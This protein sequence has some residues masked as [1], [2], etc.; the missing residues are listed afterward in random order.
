MQKKKNVIVIGAGVSGM[1]AGIYLLKN[2]FNVTLLERNSSVGGLC[3]GWYRKGRYIDGCIHWLTG[4]KEGDSCNHIWK[5]IGA[6]EDENDLIYIDTW[7]NF[8]YNGQI[9]RFLK[10]YKE[11]EKQ[12]LEIAPEDKKEIKRFFKMVSAFIDVKLP[13]ERPMDMLTFSSLM[14]VAISM[15]KHPSFL[16]TMNISTNDYAKRFK[17]PAIRWAI[18]NAQPGPGNLFSMI[19]S[20]ATIAGD[21]GAIP[22]G[23]SKPFVEKIKNRFIGMGGKLLL[24]A[25]VSKINTK[26]GFATDVTLKNGLVIKGDY[27]ISTAAPNYTLD[28]LL[29]GKYKNRTFHKRR[30]NYAKFPSISSVLVTYEIEDIGNLDTIVSFPIEPIIVANKPIDVLDIRNFSYDPKTYVNGNKTVCNTLLNQF[31][32]DYAYWEKLYKD[33]KNYRLEKERIAQEVV[34]R[35]EK[36]YP[37]YKGK[38]NILDVFTPVT[39]NRYTNAPRGAYMSLFTHKQARLSNSGVIHGLNNVYL[40]GQW[41]EAPGGLPFAVATGK[42]AAIRICKQENIKFDYKSS[43]LYKKATI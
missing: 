15:V 29:E 10:D 6:F 23:G 24:N 16:S 9:V 27:V 31:D 7:G 26:K 19:F 5:D 18:E 35:I 21:T 38:I 43:I 42:W 22:I 20:Y 14:K 37:Q 34:E 41:L 36:Q 11:A 2:G 12:W 28:V 3:T 1:S 8:N 13:M 33:K 40:A 4:T 25:D 17:N 39:L 30:D 32:S